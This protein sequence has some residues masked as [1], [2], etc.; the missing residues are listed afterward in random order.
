M[1]A[2]PGTTAWRIAGSSSPT[3]GLTD[4]APSDRPAPRDRRPAPASPLPRGRRRPLLG[5]PQLGEPGGRSPRWTVRT[6]NN[7]PGASRRAAQ[8]FGVDA[9]R[10]RCKAAPPS[11]GAGVRQHGHHQ[12]APSAPAA[13]PP[14][15]M[16]RDLGLVSKGGFKIVASATIAA[17]ATRRPA[18][19]GD[20]HRRFMK[21]AVVVRAGQASVPTGRSDSEGRSTP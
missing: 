1:P 2:S 19:D 7:G 13:R 11:D 5:M 10:E 3:A 15:R 17:R 18:S 12:S 8:P 9:H 20:N 16:A 14:G 21:Q 6:E 4:F